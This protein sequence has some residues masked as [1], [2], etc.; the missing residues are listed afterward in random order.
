MTDYTQHQA[1]LGTARTPAAGVREE[2][3]V[4]TFPV[5][6][7]TGVWKVPEWREGVAVFAAGGMHP[8]SG[9]LIEG[10]IV[11]ISLH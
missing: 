5:R 9:H 6:L 10:P 4:D 8:L 7:C 3:S 2:A 1:P 11:T